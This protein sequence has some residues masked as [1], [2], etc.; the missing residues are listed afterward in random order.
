MPTRIFVLASSIFL[1]GCAGKNQEVEDP[2]AEHK[3]HDPSDFAPEESHE[4]GAA[5]DPYA[6]MSQED[7]EG[8]ARELYKEAELAAEVGDWAK[9]V[10]NYEEAY[11]LMPGKH[12]FALKVGKAAMEVEDC[13][14]AR[15][16]LEHFV[17]YG[18]SS[19]KKQMSEAKALLEKARACAQG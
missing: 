1:A 18:D 15:Q 3:K 7:R 5:A 4:P 11:Y 12:G 2:D 14:K 9:A 10:K 13:A 16:Y 19:K 17:Q 6:G 8:K